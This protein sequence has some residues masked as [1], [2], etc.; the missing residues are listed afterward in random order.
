MKWCIVAYL[1]YELHLCFGDFVG[2]EIWGGGDVHSLPYPVSV[3]SM[4]NPQLPPT[5]IGVIN[6]SLT[7]I[8]C[9]T[10]K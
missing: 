8:T 10:P 3:P 5:M 9:S 1:G 2:V 6:A 4:I 7:N